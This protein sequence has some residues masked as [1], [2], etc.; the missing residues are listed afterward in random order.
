[1]TCEVTSPLPRA[2]DLPRLATDCFSRVLYTPEPRLGYCLSRC[3]CPL[4][5]GTSSVGGQ[6][7][8]TAFR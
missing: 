2:A 3:P 6:Q 7:G 5:W 1:M 8:P 4:G